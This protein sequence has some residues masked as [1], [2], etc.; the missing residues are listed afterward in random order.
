[1]PNPNGIQ[2]YYRLKAINPNVRIIFVTALLP[3]FSPDYDLI[4]KPLERENYI[5]RIKTALS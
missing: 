3:G 1:M 5:N 4:K 2:L